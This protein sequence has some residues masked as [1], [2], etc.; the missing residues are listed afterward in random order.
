MLGCSARTQP[1]GKSA[2]RGQSAVLNTMVASQPCH[3][4][5]ASCESL[6]CL[7]VA[8]MCEFMDSPPSGNPRAQ[9]RIDVLLR[10]W[11]AYLAAEGVSGGSSTFNAEERPAG[12][13]CCRAGGELEVRS[14]SYSYAGAEWGDRVTLHKRPR[15]H[16][17]CLTG[18]KQS[19]SS[20]W[21]VITSRPS[22]CFPAPWSSLRFGVLPRAHELLLALLIGSG[23]RSRS[24]PGTRTTRCSRRPGRHQGQAQ[25]ALFTIWPRVRS[26]PAAQPSRPILVKHLRTVTSA[27]HRHRR[28]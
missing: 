4:A 21:C 27:R 18:R 13:T 12:V 25:L 2:A 17:P 9:S 8:R 14:R 15:Q 28:R 7:C 19:T 23:R 16:E 26:F 24:H 5:D 10:S 20:A 11:F 1:C 22:W 3:A 6:K